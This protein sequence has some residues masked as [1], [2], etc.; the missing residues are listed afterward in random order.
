MKRYLRYS[1]LVLLLAF[2]GCSSTSTSSVPQAQNPTGSGST[3]LNPGNTSQNPQIPA[4]YYQGV[5]IDLTDEVNYT[6]LKDIAGSVQPPVVGDPKVAMSLTAG[7][8]NSLTGQILVAFED[9]IGFWAAIVNTFTGTT[10]YD[11]Q[12]IDAIF[13]DNDLV[14]R[15]QGT[16][17][18][19][20][21]SGTIYYRLRQ[22]GDTECLP[23]TT[24]CVGGTSG[25]GIVTP[26]D[27]APA[28]ETYMTPGATGVK[29]LGTFTNS[30]FSGTW[31]TTN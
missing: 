8:G 9:Q 30:N 2:A 14:F 21:L 24:T 10:Y 16:I 11:G 3:D 6:G 29:S 28:C 12:T 18:N 5:A 19:N 23:E 27:P 13:S 26:P 17:S 25:C 1:C 20:S 4:L 22:S 15:T 7:S 31:L